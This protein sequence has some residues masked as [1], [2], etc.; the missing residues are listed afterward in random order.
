MV[1]RVIFSPLLKSVINR[2]Q[3]TNF[4]NTN[5]LRLG[6]KLEVGLNDYNNNYYYDCDHSEIRQG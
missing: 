2:I 6:L 4:A 1:N 5:G 3:Q